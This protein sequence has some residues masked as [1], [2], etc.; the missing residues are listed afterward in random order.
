MKRAW[1]LRVVDMRFRWE[2]FHKGK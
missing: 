1:H 2:E